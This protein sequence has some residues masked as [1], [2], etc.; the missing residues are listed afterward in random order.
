MSFEYLDWSLSQYIDMSQKNSQLLSRLSF[1]II[2][3]LMF[4]GILWLGGVFSKNIDEPGNDN[5]NIEGIYEPGKAYLTEFSDF[6][7]P[8]CRSYYPIVEQLRQEFRD[9]LFFEY[10][11]F[12]VGSIKKNADISSRAVEA[13]KLQGKFEEMMKI[14]FEKQSDWANSNSAKE[15]LVSYATS[16][17]MDGKKISED[18]DSDVVRK[19]VNDDFN[20]AG[21]LG[22]TG[23]P[24]F[25]V[26]GKKISGPA[27]YDEFKI[28][29]Q[30]AIGQ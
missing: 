16:L 18:M 11:Y 22:L 24:S 5:Q 27:N 6:Q 17:G 30:Q 26:N 23:T 15:I 14:V 12:G 7:C 13:A 21:K 8:A 2:F 29:I 28:V 4:L 25:F 3:G 10:K 9:K 20:Q 19:R 1:L